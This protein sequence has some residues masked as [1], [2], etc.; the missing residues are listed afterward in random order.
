MQYSVPMIKEKNILLW[1]IHFRLLMER[2]LESSRMSGQQWVEEVSCEQEVFC[3][4]LIFG[5]EIR[6][7]ISHRPYSEMAA[8]LFLFCY[9]A[10]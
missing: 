3:N 6:K 9:C 8:A 4:W 7:L 10:N 2:L 1:Q 5:N